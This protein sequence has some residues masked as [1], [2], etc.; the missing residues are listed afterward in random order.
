MARQPWRAAHPLNWIRKLVVAAALAAAACSAVPV[1]N[2][3]AKRDPPPTVPPGERWDP[4]SVCS[5][6]VLRHESTVGTGEGPAL[7]MVVLGDSILWGQGLLEEQKAS[8]LVQ[9]RLADKFGRPVRKRVY[10]HSGATVNQSVDHLNIAHGEVPSSSPDIALQA[11]CVPNPGK[12]D[13][14]LVNGCINDVDAS[15]LFDPT[16]DAK[17]V[18]LEKLC[19]DRCREPMRLLLT[20]IGKRFPNANI[21]VPGYYPFFSGQTPAN[22]IRFVRQLF[23]LIAKTQ[24]EP[25]GWRESRDHMIRKSAAWHDLSDKMLEEAVE[26]SGREGGISGRVVFAP[27]AFFPENAYGAPESYL[28]RVTEQDE[29]LL[30]RWWNCRVGPNI[31]ERM[32]CINASAFHP[33]ANGA[34]AYADAILRALESSRKGPADI[35]QVPGEGH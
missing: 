35:P 26:E 24:G 28:R 18:G 7:E 14:V 16:T 23:L 5:T 19:E 12:V 4:V 31:L 29:V 8:T 6:M 21:V 22:T 34:V 9:R 13:V 27:V 32:R 1:S 20:R 11:E 2:P 17:G 3:L 15:I 30:S 33:N 25:H 10:A